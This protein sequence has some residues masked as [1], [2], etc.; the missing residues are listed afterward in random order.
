MRYCVNC[1]YIY[2]YIRIY[3]YIYIYMLPSKAHTS[4]SSHADS[5]QSSASLPHHVIV[6]H[7]DRTCTYA[8]K[9]QARELACIIIRGT[10]PIDVVGGTSD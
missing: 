2:I 7:E 3:I 6:P 4:R 10:R 1:G 9:T 5:R 8:C